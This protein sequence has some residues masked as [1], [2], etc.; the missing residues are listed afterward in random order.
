MLTLFEVLKMEKWC[1]EIADE[2]L[3]AHGLVLND[4]N[5][6]KLAVAVGAAVQRA[7]LTL[8]RLAKGEIFSSRPLF[9]THSKSAAAPGI[10]SF[11]ATAPASVSIR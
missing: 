6:R 4:Q 1:F 2:R 9:P 11:N 3:A 10:A 5:R 8:A 7:S